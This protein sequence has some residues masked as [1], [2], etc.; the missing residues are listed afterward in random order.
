MMALLLTH[1]KKS[2]FKRHFGLFLC[3]LLYLRTLSSVTERLKR[4]FN[5][6]KKLKH[7]Y[8]P[9]LQPNFPLLRMINKGHMSPFSFSSCCLSSSSSSSCCF[10]ENRDKPHLH[11]HIT[12]WALIRKKGLLCLLDRAGMTNALCIVSPSK[13]IHVCADH[14]TPICLVAQ[15][16]CTGR[17]GS[18]CGPPD[19]IPRDGLTSFISI[20]TVL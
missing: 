7:L 12:L 14:S 4:S 1:K 9:D 11:Y 19:A 18:L 17:A 16:R 10:S 5:Y 2:I 13:H 15:E 6:G 3:W 20:S 8:L